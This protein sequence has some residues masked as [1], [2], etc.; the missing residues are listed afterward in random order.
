MEMEPVASGTVEPT[1]ATRPLLSLCM[2]VRNESAGLSACLASTAGIVDEIVVVDTG[3]TDDTAAIAR[4]HGARVILHRWRD[5]FAAARNVGL[6]EARGEWILVLDADETLDGADGRRLRQLVAVA[7]WE[8]A[9]LLVRNWQ[10]DGELCAYLDSRITRLFRNRPAYR[11]EGIVHE[12]I[13]PAISRAGGGIV[14]LE[15]TIH[16]SGSAHRG[17]G[18]ARERAARN[19][20]L[21]QRALAVAPDD[22]YLQY[23]YGATLKMAGAGPEARRA[24][25]RALSSGRDSL[26]AEVRSLAHMKLGQLAL[27]E[28]RLAD[29]RHHAEASLALEP[30]NLLSLCILGLSAL[31]A[32]DVSTAFPA[33]ARARSLP[34]QAQGTLAKLDALIGYCRGLLGTEC[35]GD[36]AA[37]PPAPE[38]CK[39]SRFRSGL[40]V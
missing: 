34:G 27:Q 10:P 18:I 2:I 1:D 21:L 8:G 20:R 33:L 5:E 39:E 9:R 3:S 29:A 11:F 25:E 23:Q 30:E 17:D 12:Q 24:L 15:V 4:R 36:L 6:V 7:P 26:T 31:F 22:P 35:P 16:H 40:P 13:T 14:D 38:P 19:A 28:E 37:R 32:R